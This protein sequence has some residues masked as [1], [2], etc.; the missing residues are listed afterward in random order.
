MI[1]TP[2]S[3]LKYAPVFP[4]PP[5]LWKK[6]EPPPLFLNFLK[7]WGDSN[8]D[9]SLSQVKTLTRIY[10]KSFCTNPSKVK[11]ELLEI[12]QPFSE[13]TMSGVPFK[14]LFLKILWYLQKRLQCR[15]FHMK[16][17]KFL[18]TPLVAAP[19]AKSNQKK[20]NDRYSVNIFR[21]NIMMQ[22]N[23]SN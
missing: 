1:C 14:K 4:T 22:R 7:G 2:F 9:R 15:F 11:L 20:Q 19:V 21:W 17:V 3:F 23:R 8:Y 13:A 6:L 16:F 5:F 12:F 18:R 10:Y